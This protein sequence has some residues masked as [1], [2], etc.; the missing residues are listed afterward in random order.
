M[1]AVNV[2]KPITLPNRTN[3]FIA[4]KDKVRVTFGSS[5]TYQ[6]RRIKIEGYEDRLYWEFRYCNDF[7]GKTFFYT[8]TYNDNAMP[9]YKVGTKYDAVKK[10]RV[11][12]YIN[13]FDYE[14]LRDFQ[15]GGFRKQLLR[16]YG[17]IFKLFI[18][19]EL[20]DGKGERGMHNNPHYHMLLF[21]ENAHSDKYPFVSIDESTMTHLVKL[22]WQGF[23]EKTD[24]F[25]DYNTA[26]YGIVKEGKYGAVVRDYRALSYC[27]KYVTKDVKLV[28]AE[29]KIEKYHRFVIRKSLCNSEEVYKSFFENE[30]MPRFN[31]P[32]NPKKTKWCFSDVQ[33]VK[34]LV[35]D[36]YKRYCNVTGKELTSVDY[37]RFGEV[38]IEKYDLRTAF[39]TFVDSYIEPLVQDKLNEWRNRYSNKCR[40]SHG[41]GDYAIKFIQDKMNPSIQVPSKKGFKNRPITMYY[42]RK[43]Y[44]DVVKDPEGNNLYVLN[45]LG[46][47]YKAA[48]LPARIDSLVSKSRSYLPLLVEN[49]E[50]F[51]KMK[52]SDINTEV[53]MSHRDLVNLFNKTLKD[54]TL[55]EILTRYAQYKLV[56]Q[57]RFFSYHKSGEDRS[58]V[59]PSINLIDDYKRFLVPSFYSVSRNDLR[60]AC[61]LEDIP[62]N[63][64]AYSQHPYFSRF[65]GLFGV[66]DMCTDYFFIQSD[67]EKQRK[68]EEIAATKRFH[69]TNELKE[70]YSVFK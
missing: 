63:Y 33:L 70:F 41:V 28:Q 1:I 39:E 30:I 47:A 13:C 22:Y 56:Y 50:L 35:P 8:L 45:E 67:N 46:Q 68:A 54:F 7:G 29:D 5:K 9:R 64:M 59:F 25:R 10:V 58:V 36:D 38:I 31:T 14:D 20:G 40:I 26:K 21:V 55:D 52:D 61:F 51:K 32:L 42:Y 19:A 18:G 23:D 44:C 4:D 43:M 11:D 60:L 53:F 12:D 57:D 65:L 62:E 34:E 66:L 27:A 17:S 49:P 2:K 15:N 37:L 16:K 6:S 24:G 48:S 3:Y 69:S